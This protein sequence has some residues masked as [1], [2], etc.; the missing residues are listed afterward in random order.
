MGQRGSACSAV[1]SREVLASELA[2]GVVLLLRCVRVLGCCLLT[3][4]WLHACACACVTVAAAFP[5][6]LLLRL[7]DDR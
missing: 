5:R 1:L 4:S 6:W 2:G 3:C 7:E